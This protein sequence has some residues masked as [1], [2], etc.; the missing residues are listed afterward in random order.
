M[1]RKRLV[2]WSCLAAVGTAAIVMASPVCDETTEGTGCIDLGGGAS[3][4]F[5]F[6]A[7][8]DST[9]HAST[10]SLHYEDADQGLVVDSAVVLDYSNPDSNMRGFIFEADAGWYNQARLIV[11]DYGD[12]GDFFEI[13]LQL[14][15]FI[16]YQKNGFLTEQCG[17]GITIVADCPAVP[18]VTNPGTGTPGYWMNHPEAWPLDAITIGGVTYTKAEAIAAVKHPTRGDV[19]YSMFQALVAATLNVLIGNESTCVSQTIADGN[20][21]LQAFPLGAGVTARS[22]AWKDL[23]EALKNAL[24]A[25]NNGQLCA[26]SR[27]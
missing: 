4:S 3:G 11:W 27:D 21:W 14:N 6:H 9:T 24:D 15:G 16:V 25:Y 10:G 1:L 20:A 13:Q 18:P 26:P 19:S 2:K 7:V 5:T 8:F 23:G 17:G 12:S 22:A